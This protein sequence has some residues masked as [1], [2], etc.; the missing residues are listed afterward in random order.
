MK[1]EGSGGNYRSPKLHNPVIPNDLHPDVGIL[2]TEHDEVVRIPVSSTWYQQPV[3]AQKSTRF[4]D[5]L[6]A[7]VFALPF[8]VTQAPV[9]GGINPDVRQFRNAT[10]THDGVKG[11]SQFV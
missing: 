2:L 8:N 11:Y 4:G 1:A 9:S 10:K 5:F 3:S 6:G 7:R